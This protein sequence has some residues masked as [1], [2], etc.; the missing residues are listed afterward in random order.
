[1]KDQREG[2]QMEKMND[3][4]QMMLQVLTVCGL[5]GCILLV[6]CGWRAGLLTSPEA[7]ST[8]VSGLG[9]LGIFVFIAFQAVQVV[10]PVLP[11]NLGCLAGVMMFG[12]W[13]GFLFNYIGIC[14][15]S[16]MAFGL[17]KMYGR[18]LLKKLFSEK[19]LAKYEHWTGDGSPF[20]RLFA[21][22][23]FLP[24]AP[25]DFLCYLAGTTNMSWKRFTII[26]LLGKPAALALY[27]MGLTVVWQ[28]IVRLITG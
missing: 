4:M 23:I 9:I 28:Q 1:M 20:A 17:A 13:K 5:V 8:F 14:L 26:I 3:R 15:G 25:D 11:G 18:P 22:A 2:K 27:S 6:V 21:I 19:M 7:M 16:L 12:A 24:V 10:L